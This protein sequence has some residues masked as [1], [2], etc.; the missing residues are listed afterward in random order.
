MDRLNQSIIG[1][2]ILMI[3]SCTFQKQRGIEVTV[4][5]KSN[6]LMFDVVVSTSEYLDSIKIDTIISQETVKG[7]LIM[8]RTKKDGSYNISFN[9][10]GMDREVWSS[11][12]YTNGFPSNEHILI[13]IEND[14]TKIAFD[15]DS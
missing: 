3:S 12:Y 4:H 11:G 9:R 10:N 8:D 5:N 7:F 14:T 1:V 13:E 15:S 2:L 6:D